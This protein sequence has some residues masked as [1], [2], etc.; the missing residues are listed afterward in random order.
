MK[1]I[2]I[3][4]K[5]FSPDVAGS[6]TRLNNLLKCIEK[7]EYKVTIIT[8]IPHYPD[9][10]IPEK[11]KKKKIFFENISDNIT[12]IRLKMPSIPHNSFSARMINYLLFCYKSTK[13]IKYVKNIDLIWVT[14]PN[15][16]GNITGIFYKMIMG[17]PL[18]LNVD[19]FWP[20]VIVS[21][22]LIKDNFL[23]KLADIFNKFAYNYCDY[24]TPISSNI[25]QAVIEKYNINSKKIHLIE[26][27]FDVNGFIKK[28]K[29]I[30]TI[31]NP[32]KNF[33]I[34]YS[35]ILGPGY[36]FKL[37]LDMMQIIESKNYNINCIIHGKGPLKGY[38][39]KG[40]KELGLNRVNVINKHFTLEDYN[41]F[42]Q[43]V[44]I[45]VLPMKKG[46]FNKTAI[47]AKLFTYMMLNKP[48]IATK[49]GDVEKII[50]KS[51]VGL[52][53]SHNP[54]EFAELIIKMYED[55]KF[56]KTFLDT[57]KKY[58]EENYSIKVI[59]KKVNALLEEINQN[60]Q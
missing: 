49:G 4:A 47:P 3:I 35:G 58:I 5:H 31:S 2:C 43:S 18:I 42:L 55:Q 20:D 26:V 39:E 33:N 1:E 54:E 27:G 24:I 38:I 53:T 46:I 32:N 22:G 13:A 17:K 8:T 12:I 56:Y 37:I 45:S 11:Y 21:L 34:V 10:V 57:G 36:D 60:S 48:I 29:N 14:N 51:N 23:V 40:I 7:L 19:D 9:G 16:F 50:E 59:K 41:E 15:F 28:N 25:K 6:V 52:T 44:S 30:E